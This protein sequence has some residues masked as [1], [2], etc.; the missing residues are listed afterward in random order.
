MISAQTG[1][2]VETLSAAIST[3]LTEEARELSVSI[4]VSDGRRIAWLHAHGDVLK[5]DEG[6]G[7][8]GPVRE[9]IVRLNPKAL[10]QFRS[11]TA[12]AS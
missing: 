6:I 2:G 5:D 7:K 10:G 9:M 4:P 8:D 11:L 3:M 1:E 12:E